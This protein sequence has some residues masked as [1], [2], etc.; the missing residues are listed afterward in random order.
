MTEV[1]PTWYRYWLEVRPRLWIL[2]AVALWM[3]ASTPNWAKSGRIAPELLGTGLALSIGRESL[4]DW[5][6]FSAQMSFFAWAAALCLMGNG[7]R[8]AWVKRDAS[9]SYMLTLPVSR[10]RLIWTQQA[11]GWIA[12]LFASALTLLAQVGILVVQGRGIPLVP[13]TVAAAVGTVFLIAWI[14][15]LS[16]LS[17]VMHEIWALLVSFPGYLMSMRW[18]TSAATSFPA[19]GEVPW[20]SMA[21]LLTITTLAVAFSLIQSRELEFE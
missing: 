6:A 11:C 10:E 12:A 5:I 9:A 13:L 4:L 19:Y 3:G 1:Y 14:A 16:A 18:V 2:A 20:I 7:L 15:V 21:A 8:T 17:L